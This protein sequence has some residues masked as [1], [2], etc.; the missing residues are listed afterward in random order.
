MAAVIS[1]QG[2]YYSTFSY[3]SEAKRMD[4]VIDPPDVNISDYRWRGC[5]KRIRVGL[6]ALH[7]LSR[8]T[9]RRL[10]RCRG[11]DRFSSVGDF[12]RRVRPAEDEVRS[13]I[14]SGAMDSLNPGGNRSTLFWEAAVRNQQAPSCRADELF[15]ASPLA[16]PLNDQSPLE[17]LRR[18]YRA[19]G[20]LCRTHPL[21][22]IRTGRGKTV[23]GAELAGHVG[24]RVGFIGWLLTGKIVSTRTGEHMEFLT[25]EDDT[26]IVETTF[27]PD[28]Y[29]R[30][31]HML[32]SHTP[33]LL[34]GRVE[35]DFGAIT[36][37]V[38][39]LEWLKN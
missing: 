20:F 25:F 15:P 34:R 5:R 29:H 17:R 33:Y 10:I 2:G 4:L 38:E 27:F 11:N 32:S 7:N 35:E 26:A 12:L 22:L 19:L 23:K 36:L 31:A 37:T 24:S 3:V 16:P 14:D 21:S 9:V 1:N 39:H 18:E 30:Y 13:L 8:E 28:V 6:Q